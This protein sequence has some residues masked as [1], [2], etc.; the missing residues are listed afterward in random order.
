MGLDANIMKR[1]KTEYEDVQYWRKNWVLQ[2]WMEEENCVDK[3]IYESTIEELLEYIKD[4][5]NHHDEGSEGWTKEDWGVFERQID[6][7]LVSM[8][9]NESYEYIYSS[10]W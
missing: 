4:E 1:P 7:V 10:W 5:D 2:N 3:R 8:R 9:A 6:H